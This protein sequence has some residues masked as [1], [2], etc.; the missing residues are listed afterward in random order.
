MATGRSNIGSASATD[1]QPA[2][3]TVRRGYDPTQVLAHLRM[4]EER[5]R[6]LEAKLRDAE[7]ERDEARRSKEV[8]LDSLDK[9]KKEPYDS[10]AG[11]L[12]DLMRTFDA[13]VAKL[14]GEADSESARILGE[15]R[16][17]ADR[18][19]E[20][21]KREEAEARGQAEQRE[22]QAREDA[23]RIVKEARE[24]ADQIE[25]NLV[26]VYGSTLNELR[27][28]RDNMQTAVREIDVVLDERADEPIVI[29][30]D[31]A[32]GAPPEET[33]AEAKGATPTP[34][35][36]RLEGPRSAG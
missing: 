18:I 17:E 19:H 6:V 21:V 20:Q 28:I 35:G 2:F 9:A 11:R 24:E 4:V 33:P 7:R 36:S 10:M 3:G 31:H 32:A 5:I 27:A 25:S 22:R 23:D 15:A 13:E 14:R 16:R 34:A 12:A 1:P 8:A 29:H 30:D 26:A